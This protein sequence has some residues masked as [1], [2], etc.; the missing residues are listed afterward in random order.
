MRGPVALITALAGLTALALSACVTSPV[1]TPTVRPTPTTLPVGPRV[2]QV[3]PEFTLTDL[4]GN[5]V[6]LQSLRD[7]GKPIVLFFFA[8]W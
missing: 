6:T 2:G 4:Q 5:T 8:T 1:A 7:R 3:A